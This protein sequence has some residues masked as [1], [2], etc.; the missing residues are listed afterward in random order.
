MQ[1][2][3]FDHLAWLIMN[4]RFGTGNVRSLY[5]EGSLMTKEISKYKLDLMGVQ[6]VRWDRGGTEPA[7]EYTLFTYRTIV[8][9]VVLHACE[10]WSLT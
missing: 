8:L 5:S 7:G 2:S 4:I 1:F 10:T 6:E 9:P 3:H